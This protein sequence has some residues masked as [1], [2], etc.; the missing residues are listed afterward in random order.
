LKHPRPAAALDRLRRFAVGQQ[1]GCINAVDL[2]G[3]GDADL[4]PT[5]VF[6]YVQ[7]RL[8]PTAKT[9]DPTNWFK[10]EEIVVID[11]VIKELKGMTAAQVSGL[12]HR[13]RGW[14]MA[15]EGEPIPYEAAFLEPDYG[16]GS[17]ELQMSRDDGF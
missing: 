14:M 15:K 11:E 13:E 7:R 1:V 5:Q 16:D 2:L 8:I 17:S 9:I 4:K 10:S 12:S 3:E 6:N